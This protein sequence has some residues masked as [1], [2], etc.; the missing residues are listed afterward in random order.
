MHIIQI[1]F[2]IT[3]GRVLNEI[4]VLYVQRLQ[5]LIYLYLFTDCFMKI[6]NFRS[7]IRSNDWRE[8]FMKQSVNKYRYINFCNLCAIYTYINT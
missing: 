6:S 7:K 4:N 8:I 5:K 3:R 1:H 2:R